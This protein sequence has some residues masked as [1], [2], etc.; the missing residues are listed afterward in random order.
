VDIAA[1]RNQPTLALIGAAA[2]WG[3][4]T[5]ISKRAVEELPPL[6]LLA[7][8]LSASVVA[9]GIVM[10]LAGVPFRD[11]DASPVLGRLGILNP[12]IAYLLSLIGLVSIGA[13][14]SVLLWATEP[15]WILALAAMVLGER[16]VPGAVVASVVAIAGLAL[17]V[18]GG[19]GSIAPIGVILS[20]AGVIC[21]AIYT[22]VA[23]RWIGTADGT[24]PVVLT[25]Q[26]YALAVVLVGI[27]VVAVSGQLTIGPVSS[28]GWASAIASGL[29]YYATAYW[30]YLSALREL[31][32]SVASASFYLIPV[33]GV[34]ASVILLGERLEPIQWVGA[35][36]VIV[37][38]AVVL[39]LSLSA[40]PAVAEPTQMERTS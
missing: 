11:P 34:S 25:Q 8:Q 22:V 6:V 39:R 10:R 28:L 17:V 15:L 2:S 21:C 35:V 38:V 3:I 27:A 26:L 5:A 37:A 23:R 20:I 32:A 30:L 12:G 40:A 7:V 19:G 24:A 33:F 16:L 13:S 14:V 36:V 29:L 1:T 4:A 9:L 18:A 31:P